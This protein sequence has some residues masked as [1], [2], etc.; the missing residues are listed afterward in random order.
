MASVA[1]AKAASSLL[2]TAGLQRIQPL[3]PAVMPGMLFW[4]EPG[5]MAD[6]TLVPENGDLI[7]NQSGWGVDL[8]GESARFLTVANTITTGEVSRPASGAFDVVQGR[9]VAAG[10]EQFSLA[11]QRIRDHIDD[12]RSRTWALVFAYEV[13]EAPGTY[14]PSVSQRI[15]GLVDSSNYKTAIALN[16]DRTQLTGYPT[17]TTRVFNQPGSATAGRSLAIT[18]HDGY[19]GAASTS[20]TLLLLHNG[21]A[22]A[23]APSLRVFQAGIADLDVVGMTPAAFAAVI[24]ARYDECQAPGGIYAA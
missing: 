13:L 9:G 2:D 21:G 16:G 3:S 7:E 15:M 19:T 18:V 22:G 10:V 11:N 20:S 1:A 6:R 4:W 5:T 23:P 14:T 17:G 12:N 8:L 24:Q